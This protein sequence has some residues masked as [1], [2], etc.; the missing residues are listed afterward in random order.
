GAGALR[1]GA[2]QQVGQA[3][4]EEERAR[5]REA[6][7]REVLAQTAD[8]LAPRLDEGGVRRVARE[9]LDPEGARAREEVEPARAG[10]LALQ[11]I[12]QRAAHERAHRPRDA[13]LRDEE[14]AA[15]E[16]AGQ[17]A[18]RAVAIGAAQGGGFASRAARPKTVAP[19]RY[20]MGVLRMA[21]NLFEG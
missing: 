19:N 2:Q 4:D 7:T 10:D 3:L 9:R 5:R 1:R 15:A 21:S 8:P 6:E 16:S 13:A 11:R 17:D 20:R 18:R 14:G 12:E